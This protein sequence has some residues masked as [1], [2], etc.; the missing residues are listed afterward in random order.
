LLKA[1]LLP[2]K[3]YFYNCPGL[4][5]KKEEYYK[6]EDLVLGN[7]VNIYGRNCHIID[8]DEFTR[9]WYKQK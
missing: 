3:A 9:N 2:K 1:S 8:C 6:P 5:V 7:Y 4:N